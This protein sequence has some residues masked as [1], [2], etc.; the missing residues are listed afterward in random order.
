ML[1]CPNCHK[2]LKWVPKGKHTCLCGEVISTDGEDLKRIE[3]ALINVPAKD[4][5]HL[6]INIHLYLAII[7]VLMLVVLRI[8]FHQMILPLEAGIMSVLFSIDPQSY[9]QAFIPIVAAAI[10]VLWFARSYYRQIRQ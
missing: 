7:S 4:S 10:I 6:S 3:I 5:D 1:S 2:E 8:F 9:K